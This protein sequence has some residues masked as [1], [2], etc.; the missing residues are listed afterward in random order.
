MRTHVIRIGAMFAGLC[1]A[2]ALAGCADFARATASYGPA[3]LNVESPVAS[4]VQAAQT[5]PMRFPSFRDVP[6]VVATADLRTP[7]QWS[8]TVQ[9]L[10]RDGSAINVWAQENPSL[11]PT[12]TTAFNDAALKELKYNAGDVPPADQALRSEG[13][14]NSL[15]TEAA[16]PPAPK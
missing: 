11:A 9:A 14:A 5:Q 12:T 10:N 15:R 2:A 4:A 16:P 8:R 13:Y 3:A 1:A 6:P 7:L